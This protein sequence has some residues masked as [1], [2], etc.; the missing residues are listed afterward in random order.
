MK[1]KFKP[2]NIAKYKGNPTNIV[3]RSSWELKLMM[4]LDYHDD[5]IWWQSEEISI[6]YRSPVD[7]QLHRNYPD[8]VV[9]LR[10]KS[11]ELTT[12]VIEVK[13]KKQTLPPKKQNKL[14]KTY[15]QEVV[16]YQINEAKWEA[17]KNYCL[18]RNYKFIKLTED[19]LIENTIS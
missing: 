7:K 17:A 16:T 12:V 15:V 19:D 10:T 13:P 4:Y 8:F 18:D 9:K 1:G 3:Y 6:R 5:V 11:G 14:T 2:R